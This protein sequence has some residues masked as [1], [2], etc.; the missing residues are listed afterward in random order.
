MTPARKDDRSNLSQK[1]HDDDRDYGPLTGKLTW[2][3][4]TQGA[5]GRLHP[6]EQEEMFWTSL[7]GVN[8]NHD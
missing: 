8:D 1:D 2:G 4:R 3:R 7:R 6:S 5:D